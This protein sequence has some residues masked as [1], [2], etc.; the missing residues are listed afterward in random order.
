MILTTPYEKGWL[1]FRSG[2]PV[3]NIFPID[4][5]EHSDY[6]RGYAVDAPSQPDN[7]HIRWMPTGKHI[8]IQANDGHA[9]EEIYINRDQAIALMAALP[10]WINAMPVNLNES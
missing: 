8:A 9:I 4:T 10:S 7:M 6:E 1:D 2:K 3:A 5:E